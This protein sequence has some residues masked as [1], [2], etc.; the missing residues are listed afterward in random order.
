MGLKT[1]WRLNVILVAISVLLVFGLSLLVDR[2]LGKLHPAPKISGRMELIFPPGNVQDFRTVDFTYTASINSIGLRDR[3][4][5]QDKDGKYRILAIGDSFV[6]GWGVNLEDTW[7]KIAE[8]KLQEQGYNVEMDNCGKPGSG[9]P[10]YA[11]LAEKVIP[12]LKPDMVLVVM[13]Q[14][15]DLAASGPEG[16]KPAKNWIVQRIQAMY[17][18]LTWLIEERGRKAEGEPEAHQSGPPSHSTIEDNRRFS[19]ITAKNFLDKMSADERAR[20]DALEEKVKT[21]FIHGDLNAYM[22]DLALKNPKFYT[23][24]LNLDDSWIQGCMDRMAGQLVRIKDVARRHGAKVV[25]LSIPP[26]MYVNENAVK[27]I[28]RVGY[29]ISPDMIT[30]DAPDRAIRTACEHAGLPFHEVTQAFKD[31]RNDPDLFYELDYHLNAKG[32]RMY[33]DLITPEIAKEIGE[34][35]KKP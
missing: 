22:I 30:S 20:F 13:L 21:A 19:A 17:P 11:D 31:K 34:A 3:E 12:L 27:N 25:V 26:G 10:F 33:A 32:H 24:T 8:K 4:I 23:F 15:D 6:Y 14:G 9:P 7:L 16:L 1:S 28:H 2:F 35:G 5:A 29:D 18:N